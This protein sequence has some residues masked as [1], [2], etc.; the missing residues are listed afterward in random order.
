[1]FFCVN[2]DI[3]SKVITSS[4]VRLFNDDTLIKRYDKIR[5]GISDLQIQDKKCESLKCII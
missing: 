3:T 2:K 1:M 5:F 4:W